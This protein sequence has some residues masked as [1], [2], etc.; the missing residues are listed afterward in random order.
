M[1]I[2]FRNTYANVAATAALVL[3]LGGTG[4]AATS[5]VSQHRAGSGSLPGTLAHH[6]TLKGAWGHSAVSSA[7]TNDTQTASISYPIHLAKNVKVVVRQQGAGPSRACPGK[8]KAPAAR[9]GFL[10]IYVGGGTNHGK[11][12]TYSPVNGNDIPGQG[13]YKYG[14]IVFWFPITT[15]FTFASGTW[16]VTAK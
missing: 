15:D 3:T 16:A 1:K 13:N 12:K 10:C 2:G 14:A 9:P 4:Y 6:K 11:V 5:V 7:P 8:P